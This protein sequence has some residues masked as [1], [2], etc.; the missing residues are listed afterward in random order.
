M[1]IVYRFEKPTKDHGSL[2]I[3]VAGLQLRS[4][5]K[6]IRDMPGPKFDIPSYAGRTKV[7]NAIA[8]EDHHY[9]FSSL[10]QAKEVFATDKLFVNMAKRNRVKLIA[11]HVED[12][13]VIHLNSQCLFRK[14][15]AKVIAKVPLEKLTL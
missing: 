3:F 7:I 8:S 5:A 15:K 9:A 13:A 12:G 6:S 2:G 14:D 4:R 11:L 1:A 10:R